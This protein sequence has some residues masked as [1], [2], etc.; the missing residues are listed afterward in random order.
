[1][2]IHAATMQ[3]KARNFLHDQALYHLKVPADPNSDPDK[4]SW[5]ATDKLP[6]F[7]PSSTA[8]RHS[9]WDHLGGAR[10]RHAFLSHLGDSGKKR[11]ETRRLLCFTS[12][13]G[14]GKSIALEQ[15]AYLRTLVPDHI[16]IRYH[17]SELPE[18]PEHYRL[19]AEEKK[20][21]PNNHCK[22]LVGAFLRTY[23]TTATPREAG[24]KNQSLIEQATLALLERKIVRGEV[25]LIIDGLDEW[26]DPKSGK[27]RATALRELLFETY[28][29]LHCVVAG[30]PYAITSDYWDTL[31]AT[32]DS[33]TRKNAE[34]CLTSEWE[35]CLVAMFTEAQCRRLLG[36]KRYGLLSELRSQATLTPRQLEVI[37]SLPRERLTQLYS[38]ACIY[39]EVLTTSFRTDV[40]KK[41]KGL[42]ETLQSVVDE[43]QYIAY[44]SALAYVTIEH[45]QDLRT[46]ALS[47]LAHTIHDRLQEIA[48]WRGISFDAFQS[49]IATIGK[50]NTSCIEFNYFQQIDENIVWKDRT[51]LDFFAALWLVRYSSRK[52]RQAAIS[53]VPRLGGERKTLNEKRREL[54]AFVAG[55]KVVSEE[56][57]AN[58]QRGTTSSA[59]EQYDS[60]PIDA[61]WLE[62]V[63]GLF[64][65]FTNGKRPTQLMVVAWGNLE[66]LRAS[67][68]SN[69]SVENC[70]TCESVMASY[71]ADY[72][73][74]RDSDSRASVV[75]QEDLESQLRT[76]PEPSTSW[77]HVAVGHS[78]ESDNAPH[79][80]A[81]DGPYSVCA[82]PV[83]KRL[84]RIFDPGHEEVFSA[85]I[86]RY[87]EN[88]AYP[89]ICVSWWDAKMFSIW[90]H[91]RLMTEW[92]WEYFWRSNC[93][94]HYASLSN[95]YWLNDTPEEM[96]VIETSMDDN[97]LLTTHH[98][99]ATPHHIWEWTDSKFTQDS[100]FRVLR[101]GSFSHD[102]S[103]SA[104]TFRSLVDP[105]STLNYHG[106]RVA[107]TSLRR[108]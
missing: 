51:V 5:L 97:S 105:T 69:T 98:V 88:D 64:Q 96:P 32:E 31:F 82:I 27:H 13:A 100:A 90:S 17:F 41:D 101:R 61:R 23:N 49:R 6:E 59:L 16:V 92:E 9:K 50:L 42:L 29:S 39:W 53:E 21:L 73:R 54:W 34:D 81:L 67:R 102:G 58:R 86:D 22:T 68:R 103:H 35:F 25:T 74:L 45:S 36:K 48:S 14:I 108:F 8:T 106:L 89:I 76:I 72:I 52:Q 12:S 83:T 71:L 75:I 57:G 33:S 70:P 19:V 77:K 79:K 40:A 95:N 60:A 56:E 30:R 20:H 66:R 93:K 94:D 87:C 1:M 11:S 2:P 38:I 4:K 107:R 78:L 47:E 91:N 26:N 80:V 10:A 55:M 104:V 46:L 44:L 24:P 18:N 3:S 63:Q 15:I 28:P 43:R 7:E 99:G 85:D 37:R 84:Y 62:L 65:R